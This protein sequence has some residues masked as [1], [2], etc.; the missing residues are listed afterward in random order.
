MPTDHL[1]SFS[2]PIGADYSGQWTNTWTFA[3]TILDAT[4][5]A[6][7]IHANMTNVSWSG[8]TDT[9]SG[10]R[11]YVISIEQDGMPLWSSVEYE[12]STSHAVM[13]ETVLLGLPEGVELT[14]VVEPPADD[15]ARHSRGQ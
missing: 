6:L 13:N 3:I 14:V 4:G 8:F 1:F 9:C 10:M 12:G 15:R 2:D 7:Q 5:S 11:E